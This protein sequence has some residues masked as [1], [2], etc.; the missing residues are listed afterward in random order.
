[1]KWDKSS[2]IFHS[3]VVL[4]TAI[5]HR[6]YK[7]T[8]TVWIFHLIGSCLCPRPHQKE[9]KRERALLPCA[10]TQRAKRME[11]LPRT[12]PLNVPMT[13]SR[14]LYIYTA[15]LLLYSRKKNCK[16]WNTRNVD[17]KKILTLNFSLVWENFLYPPL[18]FTNLPIYSYVRSR[19][20]KKIFLLR[21][22]TR[23]DESNS[24]IQIKIFFFISFAFF[25]SFARTEQMTVLLLFWQTLI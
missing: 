23:V 11:N 18:I 24:C 12:K 20:E 1:M 10:N 5:H 19:W 21:L 17:K 6:Q 22:P 25:Y 16:H 9:W 7:H 8:H 14:S 3:R 2:R 15:R 13:F 4:P